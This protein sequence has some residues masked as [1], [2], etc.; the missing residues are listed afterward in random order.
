MIVVVLMDLFVN[1]VLPANT[2]HEHG[3]ESF[4]NEP[5]VKSFRN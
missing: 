5:A 2:K 4:S 1:P 3:H